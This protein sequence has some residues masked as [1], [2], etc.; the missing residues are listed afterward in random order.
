MLIA[1]IIGTILVWRRGWGPW[2][3]LPI[4]GALI[5]GPVIVVMA[6]GITGAVYLAD[7][8]CVVALAA[9]YYSEPERSKAGV[10]PSRPAAIPPA[11]SDEPETRQAA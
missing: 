1:E 4:V 7:L 9:M 11:Q 5:A 6:G 2:A 3:L 10:T 8:A